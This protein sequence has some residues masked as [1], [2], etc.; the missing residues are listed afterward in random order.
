MGWFATMTVNDADAPEIMSFNMAELDVSGL[1]MRL[2]LTTLMPRMIAPDCGPSYGC[3]CYSNSG[4][5]CHSNNVY[6]C[7]CHSNNTCSC[8]SN[9]CV[10]HAN[11]A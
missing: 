4:C 10:C 2:E 9:I 3:S 5:G 11:E 8:H 7:Q 6:H 1:D